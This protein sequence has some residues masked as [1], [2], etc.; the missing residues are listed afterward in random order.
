M[1]Q[2]VGVVIRPGARHEAGQALESLAH[3]MPNVRFV[4]ADSGHHAPVPPL[5]GLEGLALADFVAQSELVL[6]LGGD[7]TLLHAASMFPDQVVPLLGVNMGHIGFLTE[8]ALSELNGTLPEALAGRLPYE[9]RMRL[10]AR[11]ICAEGIAESVRQ[12]AAN[13]ICDSAPEGVCDGAP[14]GPPRMAGRILNDAAVSMRSLARIATFEVQR[15]GRPVTRVRGDGVLF[16]TPTGSTAYT[17]AAGGPIVY[18]TL[19]AIVITPICPHQLSQRP[20]VVPSDGLW[21]VTL[22]TDSD[23]FVSLDG[24][25]GCQMQRGDR[26]ELAR[27]PVPTRVLH[28]PWRDH[29]QTLRAKLRWGETPGPAEGL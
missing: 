16:A 12:R 14:G 1:K 10:D 6:V 8:I 21:S 29:F 5:P 7:G 26:L 24:H 22:A 27:A 28:P 19:D 13:R 25:H 15:N 17:L 23:V 18:P 3:E 11:V 4:V 9:D 2:T 20:L